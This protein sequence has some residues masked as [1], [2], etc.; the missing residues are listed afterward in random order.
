MG[1]DGD[2]RLGQGGTPDLDTVDLDVSQA[3]LEQLPN[4][5]KHVVIIWGTV[6]FVLWVT[7]SIRKDGV[8]S[9]VD[10]IVQALNP[11]RLFYR[12]N[13]GDPALGNDANQDGRVAQPHTGFR[14]RE[15]TINIVSAGHHFNFGGASPSA[16]TDF[17]R[18][19]LPS[20]DAA[21]AS[22]EDAREL[23]ESLRRSS[24]L[25]PALPGPASI[26]AERPQG[27]GATAAGGG[28]STQTFQVVSNSTRT[29]ATPAHD[30][31]A[32]I[33]APEAP[34][35]NDVNPAETAPTASTTT[36]DSAAPAAGD[37]AAI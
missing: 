7:S 12:G 1:G 13:A 34:F 6:W 21:S 10:K 11:F 3:I 26:P 14:D 8:S 37:G 23:V 33:T 28:A 27:Q 17:I 9:T 16:V 32:D 31:H 20:G 2:S 22:T 19:V 35:V 36:T 29:G 30:D 15:T 5:G 4:W 25:E 18:A 24:S